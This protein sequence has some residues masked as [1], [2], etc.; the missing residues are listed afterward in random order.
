MELFFC[1]VGITVTVFTGLDL[2][3]RYT[4]PK[5]RGRYDA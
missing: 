3:E 1:I 4:T 5:R 2:L